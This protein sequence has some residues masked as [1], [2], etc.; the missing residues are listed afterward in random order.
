[1]GKGKNTI[2]GRER[3]KYGFWT[4]QKVFAK[5]Q[6]NFLHRGVQVLKEPSN[7][8]FRIRILSPKN[9]YVWTSI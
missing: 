3:E 2:F 4:S 5:R 7:G 8:P 1:M 9:N 6:R